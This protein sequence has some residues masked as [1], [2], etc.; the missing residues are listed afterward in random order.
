MCYI[1]N[2][3]GLYKNDH[4]FSASGLNPCPSFAK[5]LFILLIKSFT[6]SFR[7]DEQNSLFLSLD[8]IKEK[9]YEFE[10][11]TEI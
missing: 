11:E 8:K 4:Y 2:G 5:K 1:G 3:K 9:P 10:L 7:T 6:T